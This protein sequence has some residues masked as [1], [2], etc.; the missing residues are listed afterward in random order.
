M[1]EIDIAIQDAGIA[2]LRT[3]AA[4]KALF[5][6]NKT[7]L[8]KVSAPNGAPYP[9]YVLG[10][11]QV[12]GDDT[13]C[14]EGSEVVVTVHSWARETKVDDSADK[15]KNM[16]AQARKALCRKLT[17]DG[18]VMDDWTFESS[19]HLIDGDGLTAHSVTTIRYLTTSAA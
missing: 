12:L 6:G 1:A 5:A 4:V 9:F 13:E 16:A 18:H 14:A 8:Y 19:L 3:T 11:I 17:L 10:E 2:A 15:A 7:R